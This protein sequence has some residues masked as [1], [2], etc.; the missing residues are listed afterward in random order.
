MDFS[1]RLAWP[2]RSILAGFTVS[3]FATKRQKFVVNP[4]T[5]LKKMTRV[6]DAYNQLTPQHR[7]PYIGMGGAIMI[8]GKLQISP[9]KS[10]PVAMALLVTG[11]TLLMLGIAWPRF[12]FPVAYLGTDWSDFLRG[13]LYGL[14]I[15]LEI[16]GLVVALTAVPATA[17]KL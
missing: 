5:L 11:L 13:V 8:L 10:V 7:H 14:S 1:W 15:V 3:G 16:S 2:E 12:A 17:R 6:L 9:A 4:V